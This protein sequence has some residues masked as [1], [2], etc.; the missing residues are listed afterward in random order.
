MVVSETKKDL[1]SEGIKIPT[2][3]DV[4]PTNR[5]EVA[6]STDLDNKPVD[7]QISELTTNSKDLHELATKKGKV[8]Y[9][10]MRAYKTVG[11]E[12]VY[13]GYSAVKSIKVK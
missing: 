12:K 11:G 10:R 6:P 7:E 9:V 8:Y 3:T 2:N 13:T 4:V 1:T 5:Q